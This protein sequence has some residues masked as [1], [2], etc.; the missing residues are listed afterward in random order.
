MGADGAEERAPAAPAPRA[1]RAGLL[2]AWGLFNP[3]FE[4]K[5]YLEAYVAEEVAERMLSKS[6]AL[7]EEFTAF[8]SKALH[9]D[10]TKRFDT[11]LEMKRFREAAGGER[12]LA[13]GEPVEHLR[14]R[15]AGDVRRGRRRV[16]GGRDRG[17]GV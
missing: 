13:R 7:R 12:P 2:L 3:F 16:R 15:P 6:Q 9:R 14:D 10:F 8:F 11:A 17:D 4:Q 1:E 5:E